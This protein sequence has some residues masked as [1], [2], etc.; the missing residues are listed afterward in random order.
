M[1]TSQNSVI[2]EFNTDSS[3]VSTQ[4]QNDKRK[5]TRLLR[6]SQWPIDVLPPPLTPPYKGGKINCPLALHSYEL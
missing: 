2:I 6:S 1:N 3:V 5:S 4:S